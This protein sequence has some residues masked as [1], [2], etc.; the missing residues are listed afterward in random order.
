M[1]NPASKTSLD[2]LSLKMGEIISDQFPILLNSIL[3]Y[4]NLRIDGNDKE[5]FRIYKDYLELHASTSYV[6]IEVAATFRADFRSDIAIEKK[7]NLKYLVYITSEFYKA[8][9]ITFKQSCIWERVSTFLSSL[10]IFDGEIIKINNNIHKY[11]EKYYCSDRNNRNISVHYDFDLNKLYKYVSGISENAEAQQLVAFLDIVQPLNNVLSIFKALL[12]KDVH[13]QPEITIPEEQ[14]DLSL[15]ETLKK[16]LYPELAKTIQ[17]FASHIDKNMK[18]YNIPDNLPKELSSMVNPED[19]KR[20]KEIRDYAILGMLLNYA[21]IDL[22][23][24]I[25]SFL[26]SDSDIE[27]RFNLLRINVI[28]YEISKKIYIPKDENSLS[29]WEQYI[30]N[31][32]CE[33]GDEYIKAEINSVKSSIEEFVKDEQIKKIRLKYIHVR[34]KKQFNL[35]ELINITLALK[36]YDEL[37]KAKNFILLLSRIINLNIKV[38]NII[39][40]IE[41]RKIQ[42]EMMEPFNQMKL[43]ISESKM[44]EDNKK[45]LTKMIDECRNSLQTKFR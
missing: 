7:I 38:V 15:F 3:S 41:H 31:F 40:E 45:T 1:N 42:Q 36:P 8:T 26:S 37:N 21:Y 35:P 29:L 23:I 22:S 25:R 34:E 13:C 30:C 44:T 4:N 18:T 12:E 17:T 28:I 10:H 20:I 2:N 39:N 5:T 6:M 16:E 14:I 19:M 43:K 9:F 32:L 11:K 27:K 33:N 24:A